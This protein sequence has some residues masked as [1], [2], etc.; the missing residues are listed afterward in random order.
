M[1]AAPAERAQAELP[2]SLTPLPSARR[3]PREVRV[4]RAELRGAPAARSAHRF[5]SLCPRPCLLCAGRTRPPPLSSDC[6]PFTQYAVRA[7]AAGATRT[8]DLGP[9][10]SRAAA[11]AGSARLNLPR[12]PWRARIT[13]AGCAVPAA[14]ASDDADRTRPAPLPGVHAARSTQ[15]AVRA[16]AAGATRTSDLGP[17][18]PHNSITPARSG[19]FQELADDPRPVQQPRTV[20]HDEVGRQCVDVPAARGGQFSPEAPRRQHVRDSRQ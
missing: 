14:P 3:S 6:P 1:G 16:T 17:P 13:S 10:P 9:R 5:S 11:R 12:H 19:R 7:T 8:S 2:V 15:Y 18:G 20:A 4:A